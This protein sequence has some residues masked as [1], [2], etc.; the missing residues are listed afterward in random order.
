MFRPRN[1]AF[2]FMVAVAVS[3]LAAFAAGAA[4]QTAP[5][6]QVGAPAPAPASSWRP[7]SDRFQFDAGYFGISA[8]T[9]LR[10]D[11]PQGGSG[12]VDFE[13]DLGVEKD[14]TTLWVD[15]A[16]RLGRRHQIKVSYTQLDRDRVGFT[17]DRSFVWGGQTYAAG[18]EATASTGTDI[19]GA[20]YRFALY[21]SDRFEIGPAIGLGY[22]WLNA[23]IRATG[24]VS[25][26]NGTETRN[27]DERATFGSATGAIGGYANAWLTN[28]FVL[29]ADYLY[30]KVS[31]DDSEA[32]V[33]DWRA[34]ADFYF[35]SHVGAGVQYK[36]YSYSYDRGAFDSRLGGELTYDGVQV[37]ASLLF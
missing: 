5:P 37:F 1:S 22:L 30:I 6:A 33:T 10:Y 13:D 16:M 15:A 36:H 28:R 7:L 9:V 34:G 17:L 4:A 31:P 29:R 14:A 2:V 8:N 23:G 11:G 18:L 24:T 26:P 12:E 32:S 25:G 35:T 21:R 27:L 19:L 20:Y 3:A